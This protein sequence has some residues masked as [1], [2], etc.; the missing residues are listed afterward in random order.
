MKR[1]MIS[2]IVVAI[3]LVAGAVYAQPEMRVNIRAIEF[4]HVGVDY[5]LYQDI[6]VHNTGASDLIITGVI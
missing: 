1:V 3:V 6:E 2:T 5:N 4:G